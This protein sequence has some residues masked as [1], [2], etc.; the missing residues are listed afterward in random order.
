MKIREID[1]RVLRGTPDYVPAD[2]RVPRDVMGSSNPDEHSVRAACRARLLEAANRGLS[3]IALPAL[4]TRPEGLSA[5]ASGKILAQEAIRAARSG[6][7]L[8]SISLCCDDER[9]YGIF[10]STVTGYICHFLDVLQ[11]GPLVTVDAIIEVEGGMV[12]IK[13]SNPPFG[14]ALPGGFVDYG[15][16]LEDAVRRE[17]REET[18]LELRDLAQFHTYSSPGRD[19]R[20]HTVTT[21]FS[22]R[23]TGLPKAGDDAAAVV[24]VTPSELDGLSFAFDHR[25]VLAD[26]LARRANS[27]PLR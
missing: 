16:S 24:V 19:P 25:Q 3:S 14:H 27:K 7:S 8:R 5:V 23:A 21:V 6:S 15:E 2:M 11:W 9:E 22:A 4:G 17:A 13:R 10:E 20:F 18:G 1:V 12:L 26:Y